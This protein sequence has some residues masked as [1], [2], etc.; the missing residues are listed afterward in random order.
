MTLSCTRPPFAVSIGMMFVLTACNHQ[1]DWARRLAG[2]KARATC[3]DSVRIEIVPVDR[4]VTRDACWLVGAAMQ[5]ISSGNAIGFGIQRED[6]GRVYA[7]QVNDVH[8]QGMK[9]ANSDDFWSVSLLIRDYAPSLEV[10]FFK[11]TVAAAIR[12][13]E[14]WKVEDARQVARMRL[15]E[16][17]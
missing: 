11:D 1:D 15:G 17:N 13:V 6:T 2:I 10:R 14:P 4:G 8:I 7:A 9:G 12:K 3:V 16:H 5:E